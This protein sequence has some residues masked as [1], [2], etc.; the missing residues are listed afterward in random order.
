M[1]PSISYTFDLSSEKKVITF[2]GECG[3]EYTLVHELSWT[4]FGNSILNI[5]AGCNVDRKVL[6]TA[7][8]YSN[9]NNTVKTSSLLE[10]GTATLNFQN[11][12]FLTTEPWRCVICVVPHLQLCE[13]EQFADASSSSTPTRKEY[14]RKSNF[15]ELSADF[16]LI[17]ETGDLS[18]V[19]ISN[20]AC[21]INA[22]KV[23]LAARSP[24]FAKMFQHPM[25]ENRENRVLISDMPDDVLR[26]MISFIYTGTVS[27]RDGA[28]ARNLYIAADKYAVKDLKKLCSEVLQKFCFDN[29]LDSLFLA[30]LYDD[31]TLKQS[32]LDFIAMNYSQ[33]KSSESW[34]NFMKENK[35]LAIE[36]LS[37]VIENKVQ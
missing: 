15:K 5:S 2:T 36:V 29:V 6:I 1:A 13:F 32:A 11:V 28:M 24:V 25:K 34:E 33:V 37:F 16:Q 19:V 12:N 17:L 3:E 14:I 10:D 21:K 31:K 23:V 27:L 20:G 9:S 26:E 4:I 7:E 22:H 35:A 18:D 30:H 8:L